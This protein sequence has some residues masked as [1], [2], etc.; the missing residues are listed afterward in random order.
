V[1][2]TESSPVA[3]FKIQNDKISFIGNNLQMKELCCEFNDLPTSDTKK[4][5][6]K[7]IGECSTDNTLSPIDQ[8]FVISALMNSAL[9]ND[10]VMHRNPNM[11]KYQ[12]VYELIIASTFDLNSMFESNVDDD[13]QKAQEEL[14]QV[15]KK[16]AELTVWFA[17]EKQSL[18][19]V[20]KKYKLAGGDFNEIPNWKSICSKA[21]ITDADL[22]N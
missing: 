21:N 7:Y 3:E 9:G 18:I 19:D 17:G 4:S 14:K 16:N 15:M 22:S 10:V 11:T 8:N 1:E 6:L 5:A 20:A 2:S 13:L 12:E